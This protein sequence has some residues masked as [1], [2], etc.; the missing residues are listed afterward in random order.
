MR[1]TGHD[2]PVAGS[3]PTGSYMLTRDIRELSRD[4]AGPVHS[5]IT[6]P[7]R[8]EIYESLL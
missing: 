5:W 7:G 6:D 1:A 8:R 4:G 2:L 3:L